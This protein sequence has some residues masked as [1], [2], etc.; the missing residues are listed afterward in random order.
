MV[1][2]RTGKLKNA[3][4]GLNT[5]GDLLF[6]LDHSVGSVLLES[7]DAERNT[8]ADK[9]SVAHTTSYPTPYWL[10]DVNGFQMYED[11]AVKNFSVENIVWKRMDGGNL[12]LPTSNARGLGAVPWTTR[13]AN[14]TAYTTGE[15][16]LGNVRFTF[17]TTNGAMLPVL[18]AQELSHP[19]LMRKH[20]YKVNNVLMIPNEEV[21]FR[22]IT[23]VDDAGEK[24]NI[25]GGSP[26]GTVIRGFRGTENRAIKGRAPALANS[27]NTPNLKVMLP[28]PDSIP[29]NIV[30]RS[31]FDPLQAYQNETVGSGGM[32][33]PDLGFI[34]HRSP[35]QQHS[36]RSL[37]CHPLTK[38]TIGRG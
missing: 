22:A 30:V 34:G 27:G 28:N 15:K 31:G 23:V 36:G 7:G 4:P 25:E 1:A 38:T 29:G 37:E 16:L 20:P 10:G 19:D 12:S 8:S 5:I 9:H 3:V 17:E 14:D 33:H 32:H 13:I 6:D 2:K 24:H 26:L 21:Q 18:Q 11:S 35:V